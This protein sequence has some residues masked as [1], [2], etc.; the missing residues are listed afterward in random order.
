MVGGTVKQ[1]KDALEEMRTIYNFD[2]E[3][4]RISLRD[5]CTISATCLAIVTTD[6]KTGITVRMDKDIPIKGQETTWK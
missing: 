1:F 3:K 4:T 2:D 5:P 6:E